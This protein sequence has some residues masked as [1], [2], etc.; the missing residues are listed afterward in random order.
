MQE[1]KIGTS[2]V[3]G[4]VGDALTPELIVDFASAFGTWAGG[5]RVVIGRDTRRSSV[6]MRSAAL[7]G[8]L[9]TGCEIIDLGLAPTPLV[10]FAVRELAAQGGISIT[11]SHNDA[12]W[13]ALKFV[14]PD[15]SLLNTVKSEEL[16][17]I[18]HSA[19]F[20]NAAWQ[21]IKPLVEDQSVSERYLEHLLSVLDADCIR[22][23]GFRVA[24]DFCNGT[25]G[26]LTTRFL[27]SLGCTLL[28]V[29]EEPSGEF[30][31]PPSPTPTNMR[32]L[33]TLMK[34]FQADLGAA[35]N[36]DGD[37]I[38]FVTSDG[39][40]LSEE[41]SLPLAAGIRLSRRAGTVTTGFSTSR[42]IDELA[43]RYGQQVIRTPVGESFVIDQGIAEG[44]VLAGEGCGGV[45]A[46][47][48]SLTF[49]GLL[50]LGLVLEQMAEKESTIAQLAG[51][52]PRFVM[53]KSE[54][55]CPPNQ[56][57][58]ML[59]RFREHYSSLHPDCTD[60]VYVKWQR[61]WLHVRASNTEPLLRIISEA[62]SD[63]RAD[64]LLE[65][66]Q[67]FVRRMAFEF[68]GR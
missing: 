68:R 29:N 2:W 64:E 12:R 3:R 33:A 40:A 66:A 59:D 56:V 48:A 62:E 58:R 5:G 20:K 18:Y 9:A 19:G 23:R 14:G 6:A 39:T 4:V 32:Q 36:V 55:P 35:I 27:K 7:S 21:D 38:G 24:V 17:D 15:G 60:G 44:A 47:P 30:A 51:E 67:T 37:R 11:G 63:E 31:H 65:Q 52:L 1:L 8:L 10:S 26:S 41:Y 28:P 22:R 50:T 45:T 43:G 25:C 53:R 42:M 13:N 49:D 16:L 54:I 46:L 34:I 61:D 57:Y